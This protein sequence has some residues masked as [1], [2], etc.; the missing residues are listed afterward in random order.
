M[1]SLTY[2]SQPFQQTGALSGQ[3]AFQY[4]SV[5]TLASSVMPHIKQPNAYLL[6]I[7]FG[8]RTPGD[9]SRNCYFR[10]A[11]WFIFVKKSETEG[12]LRRR[13]GPTLVPSPIFTLIWRGQIKLPHG[14]ISTL[15]FNETYFKRKKKW[16]NFNP[17]RHKSNFGLRSET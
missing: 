12:T 9:R 4:L 14:G 1:S 7:P 6:T 16:I 10:K 17:K 3:E 8:V 15:C 13:S 5:F 2:F 11:F